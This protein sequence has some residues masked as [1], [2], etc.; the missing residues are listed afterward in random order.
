MLKRTASPFTIASDMPF[1]E[2]GSSCYRLTD[3]GPLPPV[4]AE[5]DPGGVSSVFKECDFGLRMEGEVCP[6]A[7]TFPVD[8][9]IL[10]GELVA[11]Y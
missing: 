3:K 7:L 6:K 11:V 8:N 1:G 9:L 10:E 4:F 5:V 2:G